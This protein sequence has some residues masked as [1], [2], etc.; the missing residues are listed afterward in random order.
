MFRFLFILQIVSTC[1]I[2]ISLLRLVKVNSFASTRYLLLTGACIVA[3]SA[4]Y[5][6]EMVASDKGE[7]LFALRFEYA[8]ISFVALCFLKFVTEYCDT[9]FLP[10]WGSWGILGFEFLVAATMMGCPRT[11]LYYTSMDFIYNGIFPHVETGKGILYY[12]F[13][14]HLAV[15]MIACSFVFLWYY[16]RKARKKEQILYRL[17]FFES[18]IPISGI[19][20]NTFRVIDGYDINSL[21]LDIMYTGLIFTLTNGRL[22]DVESIAVS[23]LYKDFGS[24]IIITNTDGDYVDANRMAIRIFPE[25]NNLKSGECISS[26]DEKLYTTEGDYYFERDG[27]YYS[28]YANRLYDNNKHVG[29]IISITDITDMR[30]QIN[31][32]QHLKEA[33]D[34][35]N[36]AKSAFLANMSHEIRTPL[37]AIIG[38]ATL[39]KSEKSRDIVNDYINQIES[40]GNLLLGTVSD[41]LDISK[42]ESG[43]LTLN[44]ASYSIADLLNS[45]INITNMRIGRKPIE[46]Y[47]DIDPNIPK[48]LYGDD[49][50]LKQILM[51][52]LS[53]AEKYTD[54]GHIILKVD[55][56]KKQG[57]IKLSFSIED[58]GRGIAEENLDKLFKPFSQIDAEKNRQIESTGLGLSIAARIIE[59][60]NGTYSVKSKYGEGSTFSF[61]V[62]QKIIDDTPFAQGHEREKE[63]VKP[64]A[65]FALYEEKESEPVN[66]KP[67]TSTPSYPHASILVVDDNRVNVKVLCAFLSRYDIIA[68][69]CL[70]GKEA[71]E[72]TLKRKFDLIFMDHMMPE[73]DGIETTIA[74]RTN[75]LNINSET[76]IVA[77]TANVLKG[78]DKDFIDAGMN[79]FVPKPIKFEVLSGLLKSYLT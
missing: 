63:R 54:S 6:F 46:L 69:S 65:S 43:K 11:D 8:G 39:A 23:N 71:I 55:F 10:T 7:A 34:S 28:S 47:A 13:S 75:P 2:L 61:T 50:R 58:T 1:L 51:N 74:I 29:F 12:L 25:L 30:N 60:N 24:G 76:P 57:D 67:D 70:S 4:G 31:E 38:M 77:C 56:E 21:M 19:I 66:S 64:A 15:I 37:N 36:I 44:P 79:E 59:L 17:L 40:A 73:M 16:K 72:A 48:T 42:A 22:N 3:Y 45:V 52:F 9:H 49:L 5:A 41:V 62:L 53:N 32:M 18:L 14:I 35:A 27:I 33:A 20:I 68:E 26:I 78:I